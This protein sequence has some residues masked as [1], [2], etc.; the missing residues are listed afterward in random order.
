MLADSLNGIG[1]IIGITRLTMGNGSFP[2]HRNK[3]GL[4]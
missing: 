1:K 4:I 3:L 2:H